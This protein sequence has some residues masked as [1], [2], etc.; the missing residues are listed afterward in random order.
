MN[1]ILMGPP[2][3]G[4]GTQGNLLSDRL[5]A[6]PLSTGDLLRE[7]QKEP[8]H[9]L[10]QQVQVMQK[11]ELVSDD[12]VNKVVEQ[13]I[14]K[15]KYE[16]GVIFDGYPRTIAQAE[17]LDENLAA[18]GKKVDL[19]I[20]LDVSKEVLFYRILGRRVC[21]GCKKVYHEEQG[22]T[23]CMDCGELL[24]CRGDDNEE[25]IVQR[26]DEYRMKT[27]PLQDYYRSSQAACITI[28]ITDSSLSAME[29]NQIIAEL[30]KE[31][32][33]IPEAL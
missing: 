32:N 4:K 24:I 11:G 16:K 10:Y 14:Q 13:A 18:L 1:V 31:N 20:D 29:V 25:T 27:A 22:L 33:L 3:S 5:N 8:S 12:V 21:S 23:H 26:L 30:L 19:V 2:G 9:P 7:V 28:S 15:P 6:K 17:T